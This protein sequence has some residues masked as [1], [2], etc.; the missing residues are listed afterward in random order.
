MNYKKEITITLL[1]SLLI[2]GAIAAWGFL[3]EFKACTEYPL[4]LGRCVEISIFPDKFQAISLILLTLILSATPTLFLKEPI[5]KT[6]RLFALIA[7]PVMLIAIFLT[8]VHAR[9]MLGI[10]RESV[11]LLVSALF[12][13]T[14]YSMYTYKY[15]KTR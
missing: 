13:L 3:T 12:I 7:I 2:F 15:I 11:T 9:S 5:Y 14:S 4:S 10:D 6:W 8:P 1:L